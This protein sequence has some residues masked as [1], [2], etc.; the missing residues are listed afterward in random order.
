MVE[1]AQTRKAEIGPHTTVREA[2]QRYPGIESVFDKRGLAGCGGPDGPMEPVAFFARVHQVDPAALL[3]ELNDFAAGRDGAVSLPILEKRP[4]P[5]RQ[6]YFIAVIVALAIA[7]GGGFPLGILAA[8]GGGHDIGLGVRWTPIVQAHGH[9]QLVGFVGLFITGIAYHVLPRFKNRDLALARLSLP[10]IGLLAGGAILRAAAQPWS[11]SA[12]AAWLTVV[13]AVIELAG[14]VAFATVIGATLAGSQRK[15]YDRYLLAGAAWFV[16]ASIANL[17][18]VAQLARDGVSVIPTAR[19]APLLE[20]YAFGFIALFVLGISIRVLPHFL[21]LRPPR[22]R[23]LVPALLL[24]NA[25]L[26]VRTSAGWV[27]AY[28]SWSR[29]DW[30]LAATVY[31]MTAAAA[32]FIFALNLHLPSVRDDSADLERS[33]EKLIRSA[34]VWLVIAFAIEAW[35]VTKGL[36]GGVQ[37]DFLESGAARHA[38]AL[39][40]VTQMIFGVGSRAL[41]VFAGKQIYSRRLV[42]ISWA[43][44]NVVTLMRVG[45]AM[46]P[47]ESTVFRFDQIAAAGALGLIALIVFAYNIVRS[48]RPARRRREANQKEAHMAQLPEEQAYELTAESVA[49]D[50]IENIP[51]SL[52]VLVSYGFKPLADPEMRARVAS[53]VTLGMACSMHGIS[54]QTL[55]ADLASLREKPDAVGL[56]VPP[57]QWILNALRDCYDPEIPVNIVDLG[58]V[59]EVEADERRAAV[60]ILLT[61]PDCPAADELVAD[62]AS[63][64]RALGFASV[65]VS[66]VRQP[67]WDPSRMTAAARQ[68]LGY[69]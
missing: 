37:P 28:S 67:P 39:G 5:E 62:V 56:A 40:F 15:S 58:L 53:Q 46:I 41:P 14:A 13:S 66:I 1:S 36:A 27:D 47:Y 69:T 11:D 35:Y 7:I 52:E 48:V 25:G 63:R 9:L 17:V 29:P 24:F 26:L 68:A 50:V 10:S 18:V 22:I 33:H 16:A 6:P 43:L 34:Y 4:K 3:R 61:S 45:H 31:A 30:L 44:I 21:S 42:N 60:R 59:Y 38:L 64:V 54:V 2:V 20:M 51:G 57:R 49:A 32:L 55:I 19:D 23:Y 12:I 8:L 65:Q